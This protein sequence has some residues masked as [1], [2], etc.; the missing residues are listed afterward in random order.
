M[1]PASSAGPCSEV[2]Q[3]AFRHGTLSVVSKGKL[4]EART[5]PKSAPELADHVVGDAY[6]LIGDTAGAQPCTDNGDQ[7]KE[8]KMTARQYAERFIQA[9]QDRQRGAAEMQAAW[10]ARFIQAHQSAAQSEMSRAQ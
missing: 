1:L 9:H 8:H 4:L 3:K 6:K 7:R 10:V 2:G 5:V